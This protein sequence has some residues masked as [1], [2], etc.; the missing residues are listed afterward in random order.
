MKDSNKK[1]SGKKKKRKINVLRFITVIV[2]VAIVAIGG[3]L[4]GT[5]YG[6][7]STATPITADELRL[8]KFTS[9]VYDSKGD[10]IAHLSMD[11]NRIWVDYD[12][13][14]PHL[15]NAFVAIEDER[16]WKH[17]GI[18]IK[19]IISAAI[20]YCIPGS[21]PYG[22]S[23]ITQ[24]LVKNITKDDEYALRRK[25]QEQWRA[26][27]L[28]TKLEKWE[29]LE[30]YLNLIYLGNNV[31]GVQVASKT[32]F[33]KDAQDLN[34]AESAC[35]AGITQKPAYYDP[36]INPDKCINR[37][38][39]V[40]GKMLELGHIDQTE[41]DD[42]VNYK[43][44]FKKG[45]I[46]K[47][48]KHSYF[49]DQVIEDVVSDLIAKN[50]ISREI[51]LKTLYSNGLRIYTTQDLDIQKCMD[52]VFLD[53]KYFPKLEGGDELPQGAMVII[54][55]YSGE[56]RGIV[57]GAGPKTADLVL[58]RATSKLA[59]K[60][61]GSSIKPIAVYAPAIE[62]GILT[63]G[64]VIDDAPLY[65]GDYH[66]ENYNKKYRGLTTVRDAVVSSLNV[67]A[68]KSWLKLGAQNSVDFMKD[69]GI[70]TLTRDD[71]YASMALGGLTNGVT[72]YEMTAAYA[73]FLNRGIYTKPIT[74]T[75][76]L[77]RNGKILL[78]N[79]PDWNKKV[80]MRETSAYI[81]TDMLEAVVSQVGGTGTGARLQAGNMPVAGKTGTTDDNWDK[82]FV[83]YTPYY[84]AGVR[85]GYD[86]GKPIVDTGQA[87]R[88]WQA[89]MEKVHNN[90]APKSFEEPQGIVRKA[91]CID[92]GM[93]PGPYC[94]SDPRG[95]RIRE[96]IFDKNTVPRTVCGVH[97]PPTKVCT[98]S[99]F[100]AGDYC[101]HESI[102]EKVFIV[103]PEQYEP[104]GPGDSA[105]ADRI[106]ELPAG[107]YCNVHGPQQWPDYE[108]NQVPDSFYFEDGFNGGMFEN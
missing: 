56:V 62:A 54:D 61:P 9:V 77:D 95:S 80:V 36:F 75:K 78:E 83:G 86:K 37:Q 67:I 25:I 39:L 53:E 89:V 4:A 106:Y 5:V 3:V 26:L 57:G 90:L 33:D 74:Y 15:L 18:D 58:N 93:L 31:N 35:I 81:I 30:L 98:E 34:L 68:V 79:R 70:T 23:T 105:P 85:Y 28:E 43:L 46:N 50:S 42:A 41:Y 101:P 32:Y 10:E 99:N 17:P 52:D 16:F 82:W 107:E 108:E 47:T 45:Q 6:L 48:S 51:A 40:L 1:V 102:V 29:I 100:L 91:I 24:Q 21:D 14:P 103:K 55:P 65:I 11:E 8:N 60:R 87:V 88:I 20:N 96:E 94:A 2:I 97:T 104:I 71:R 19:R 44:E 72:V 22:A 64:S 76:V 59:V 92:S 63:A 84:A 7:I 27:Q 12:D 66:P 13:I 69:V 38:K 49:V 73:T